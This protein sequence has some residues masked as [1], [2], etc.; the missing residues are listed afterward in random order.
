MN[1]RKAC[2]GTCSFFLG[3][4]MLGMCAVSAHASSLKLSCGGRT[5]YTIVQSA[6]ASE[7]EKYAGE[8]RG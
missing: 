3:I 6:Q 2:R 4:A 8:D 1:T 7:A 5:D